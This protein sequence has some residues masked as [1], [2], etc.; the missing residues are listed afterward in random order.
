MMDWKSGKEQFYKKESEIF[1]LAANYYDQYRPSYPKEII[2]TL[3]KKTG[4]SEKSKLLE[5]GAGSGKAT[6]LLKDGG[7]N[8][9]CVEPGKNLVAI[10]NL[11]FEKYSNIRFECTR[12]EEYEAK[13]HS[14]DLIFA[15]QAF[16]WVPQPKGY[17]KCAF[18]LKEKCYL[19]LFWNMYL[20]Y[21]NEMDNELLEISNRYGGFADFMNEETCERRIASIVSDIENSGLFTKP[22]VYRQQWK[23]TYTAADYYGFALTGNSLIQ[24]SEEEKQKALKDLGDLANKHG[25]V[26]ER[27]YLCVLYLSQVL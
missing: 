19:A 18:A 11:K 20:T 13:K 14:Y 7:Y 22:D 24:K 27:P 2:D 9:C 15:A 17:E 23:K 16:H 26:I 21:D 1:N 4:I 12:F 10:G 6:E 8:I 5:I 3:I 25:G